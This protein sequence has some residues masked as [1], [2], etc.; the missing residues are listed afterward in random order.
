MATF[1]P[2]LIAS[3]ATNADLS[4]DS[5]RIVKVSGDNNVIRASA[6]TDVLIGVL[7]DG[8]ALGTATAPSGVS[9]QVA[10]IAKIVAGVNNISE[11]H[12]LSC[13]AQGRA[14]IAT[15]GEHLIGRAISS[16]SAVGDVIECLL[17]PALIYKT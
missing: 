5:Y 15:T 11:G 8:V 3:F 14:V 4:G 1:G 7:T 10:G 17:S 13:D 6:T 16:S 12:P 2:S 9:V